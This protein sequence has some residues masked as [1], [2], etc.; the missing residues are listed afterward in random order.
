MRTR[1][2][3]LGFAIVASDYLLE[4]SGESQ[5]SLPVAGGTIPSER[6]P[7]RYLCHEFKQFGRIVRSELSIV[8]CL[9]GEVG[10]GYL[11]ILGRL[12]T[13]AIHI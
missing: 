7:R 5:G 11:A 9:F 8:F 13:L 1:E 6:V 3:N 4:M 2:R 12:P 10:Q